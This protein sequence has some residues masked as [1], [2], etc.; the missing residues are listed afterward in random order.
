MTYFERVVNSLLSEKERVLIAYYEIAG[1]FCEVLSRHSSNDACFL[2]N[3][4][5]ATETCHATK[6]NKKREAENDGL[7]CCNVNF[8]IFLSSL[9]RLAEEC[10][11]CV[12]SMFFWL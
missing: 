10:W 8:L 6:N 3:N 12:I 2:R 9:F 1:Q 11:L 4:C 5:V 7:G